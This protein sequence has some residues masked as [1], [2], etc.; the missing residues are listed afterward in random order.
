MLAITHHTE[1]QASTAS[2]DQNVAPTD[3]RQAMYSLAMNMRKASPKAKR[4]RRVRKWV[5]HI[6]KRWI[7]A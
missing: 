4:E 2:H 6:K 1:E 7:H 5:L 3:L